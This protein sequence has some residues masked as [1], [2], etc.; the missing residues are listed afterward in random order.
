MKQIISTFLFISLLFSETYAKENH[1]T[2]TYSMEQLE[3]TWNFLYEDNDDDTSIIISGTNTYSLNGTLLSKGTIKIYNA[4]K[5]LSA[6][7][8]I[9]MHDEWT[10]EG[11]KLIEQVIE[12]QFDYIKKSKDTF[13]A[14]MM[15]ILLK[16][17]CNIQIKTTSIITDIS[18]EKFTTND[19]GETQIYNRVKF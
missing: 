15:N 14:M 5:T 19:D 3:G 13:V 10:V 1:K 16:S 2:K 7:T 17:M 6:D 18:P 4:D 9:I 12:C 8:N 11:N